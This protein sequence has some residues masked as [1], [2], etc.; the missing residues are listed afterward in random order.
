MT[1][2][3]T[4][5]NAYTANVASAKRNDAIDYLVNDGTISPAAASFARGFIA[6]GLFC[7]ALNVGHEAGIVSSL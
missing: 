1:A 2:V 6:F 3:N 4:I 7:D 5:L